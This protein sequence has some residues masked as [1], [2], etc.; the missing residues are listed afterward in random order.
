MH[1]TSIFDVLCLYKAHLIYKAF[2]EQED[3]SERRINYR[4]GNDK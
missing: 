3:N 2:A 1:E 4:G